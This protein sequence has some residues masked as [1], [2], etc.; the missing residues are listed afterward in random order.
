MSITTI[1]VIIYLSFL[2][3]EKHAEQSVCQSGE[4]LLSLRPVRPETD[5][6]GLSAVHTAT[7]VPARKRQSS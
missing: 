5:S 6:N 4:L 7:S 2:A 1:D 3:S